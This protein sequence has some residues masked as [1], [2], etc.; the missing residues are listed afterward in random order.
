MPLIDGMN[1]ARRDFRFFNKISVYWTL[2]IR[3]FQA[4]SLPFRG[5]KGHTLKL[6]AK[7]ESLGIIV[8]AHSAVQEEFLQSEPVF[9]K[10]CLHERIFLERVQAI[11]I[12]R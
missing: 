12:I 7:R 10:F 11:F 5:F 2:A 4:L 6:C 3:L 8:P 1:V 9:L